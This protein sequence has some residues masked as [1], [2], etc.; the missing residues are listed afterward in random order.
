[1]ITA[2]VLADSPPELSHADIAEAID[3]VVT[4]C[5]RGEFEPEVVRAKAEMEVRVGQLFEDDV[6]YEAR[7]SAFLEWYAV[8][9]PLSALV[10]GAGAPPALH[11]RALG[12]RDAALLDALAVSHRSIFRLVETRPAALLLQDLIGG[13]WWE[14]DERRRIAGLGQGDLFEARLFGVRGRVVFGRCFLSHPREVE[15]HIV[16]SCARAARGDAAARLAEC[17][18]LA[19]LRVK[20]DRYRNLPAARLY[21]GEGGSW[22]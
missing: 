7:T 6:L 22:K 9:R 16:E 15:A 8:E 21:G 3:A 1:V 17:D 18:R 11:A 4:L 10:T 13:G 14:V 2:A 20:A 19:G 12:L 5:S